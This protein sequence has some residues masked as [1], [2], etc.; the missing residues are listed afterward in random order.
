MLDLGLHLYV[1][2]KAGSPAQSSLSLKQLTINRVFNKQQL[3]ALII[4]VL[5][6]IACGR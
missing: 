2:V 3:S 1:T 5:Y 4:I 6:G